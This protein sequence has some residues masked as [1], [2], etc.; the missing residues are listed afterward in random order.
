MNP[1]EATRVLDCGGFL[2][3][4]DRPRIMAVLNVTPDSFSD[5]G[6]WTDPERALRHAMDMVDEGADIIDI[7]GESTRPGAEHVSTE[8]ELDRVI[9]LIERL[10]GQIEAS[11][12]ID[13]SKPGVMREAVAAGAGMIND[14]YALRREGALE[15]AAS[16]RVP[17]CLMHMQGEPRDM[18]QD[19]RYFDVVAE[20][21]DFLA[22]RAQ[23]CRDAG[24][25]ADRI[26]VDPG[27]GFGKS[28]KHNLELLR[29]LPE[30]A[31]LG[32]PVLA[33]L[34]RKSMLGTIAGRGPGSRMAASVAAALLAVQKGAA[35]VRVHDVA[36][37][38]D[39]L[40]VFVV[41]RGEA[42]S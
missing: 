8:Q 28:L 1:T 35:I 29:G 36:E 15:A 6:L 37:T 22:G 39:A 10:A 5:G 21:R 3:P 14:V 40:K 26:V 42:D 24:I 34:S 23:A 27:F 2:L 32:Y 13:T 33:G 7:G 31:G 4:L 17:V 25:A 20:V 16:L 30:L 12:S 11:I 9:P 41:F 38:A 18:Q 19:P